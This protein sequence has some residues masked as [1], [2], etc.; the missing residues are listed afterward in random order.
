MEH[1]KKE[2][3]EKYKQLFSNYMLNKIRCEQ[4]EIVPLVGCQIMFRC[5]LTGH[6]WIPMQKPGGGYYRGFYKNPYYK[7]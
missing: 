7:R 3:M 5:K 2:R 4:I 6:F 1:F